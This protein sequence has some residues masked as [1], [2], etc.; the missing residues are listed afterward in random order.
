[1]AG[2]GGASCSSI[3]TSASSIRSSSI[4]GGEGDKLLASAGTSSAEPAAAAAEA[5]ALPDQG[6]DEVDG[7][8]VGDEDS[9]AAAAG[10]FSDEGDDGPDA[11]CEEGALDDETGSPGVGVSFRDEGVFEVGVGTE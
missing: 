8:T 3:P 6:N 9:A 4:T 7:V 10:D 11:G 2:T 1:M 5:A